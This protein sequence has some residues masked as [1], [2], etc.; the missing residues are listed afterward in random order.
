MTQARE[1]HAPSFPML[2][3]QIM[4]PRIYIKA[5]TKP[6]SIL[7]RFLLKELA[8]QRCFKCKI[9]LKTEQDY[10]CRKCEPLFYQ[11]NSKTKNINGV[12]IHFASKYSNLHQDLMKQF[13]YE[14]PRL[15][16]IWARLLTKYW[17]K[18]RDRILEADDFDS[19]IQ[20]HQD[21]QTYVTEIP[22]HFIR[23]FSRGYNQ[24]KLI[25]KDFSRKQNF[26]HI[27]NLL[28]RK[29]ET[30]SLFDKSKS[31]REA[32]M[33]DAF[34]INRGKLREIEPNDKYKRL[35]IID[36]ITTTGITLYEA[37]KA[38]KKSLIFDEILL[39]SCTGN[40]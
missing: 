20:S 31:E 37:Q 23:E 36:D 28:K 17:K 2:M 1:Y 39:L 4:S 40:T 7:G 11:T 18:Y 32:I 22:L 12:N 38:I 5:F 13:K 19:L 9:K 34:L 29:K 16:K 14:S 35:I 15:K 6:L 21:S 30:L 25:A 24:S 3:I 33:K 26:I 8:Y 10:L 27:E